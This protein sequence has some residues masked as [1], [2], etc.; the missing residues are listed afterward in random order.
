MKPSRAQLEKLLD[1]GGGDC[2]LF[3]L[4]GPDEAGSRALGQRLARALGSEAERIELDTAT[5]KA[6]PARLADEAAAFGLFG[7]RRYI[8]VTL[9]G[10]DCEAAIDALLEAP[11]A[12]NPVI[13]YAGAIKASAALV[14]KLTA[15][16][17]AAAHASYLPDDKAFAEIADAMARERGLRVDPACARRLVAL[18]GQDR[19]IMARELDKI[20]L[21]LDADPGRPRAIEPAHLDAI[22][23]DAGDPDLAA[24]GDAVFGGKPDAA[25]AQLAALAANGVDGIALI[26]ALNRRMADLI[27]MRGEIAGGK[28]ADT[29]TA[30][31]FFKEKAAIQSQLRRWSPERLATAA[32]RMLAAERAIK[33]SGSAGPILAEAALLE[34]SRAAKR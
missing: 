33:A 2:R 32:E 21:Y 15:H 12:G 31:I 28:A 9:G 14:K 11:A 25:A 30:S 17:L 8:V 7:E 23:A 5:L 20:A 19:E 1:A 4:Y 22:A 34:I 3:L 26:R 16:S 29:V 27:R 10:A 13:A 24:L 6:D 18:S